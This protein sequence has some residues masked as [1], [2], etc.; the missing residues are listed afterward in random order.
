MNYK[1]ILLKLLALTLEATDQEIEEAIRQIDSFQ[2]E[3]NDQAEKLK[4]ITEENTALKNALVHHELAR[5][6]KQET[7]SAGANS[8]ANSASPRTGAIHA[9]HQRHLAESPLLSYFT[10]RSIAR[11]QRDLVNQLRLAHKL[12]YQEAWDEARR[13]RPDLF[14]P[15]TTCSSV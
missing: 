15:K 5:A 10:N 9:L 11:H 13:Q 12:D 1:E 3:A 7:Q 6:E 2:K 14:E 4:T 8:N